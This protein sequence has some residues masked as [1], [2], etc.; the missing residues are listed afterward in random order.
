[1]DVLH[2]FSTWDDTERGGGSR[3]DGWEQCFDIVLLSCWRI[4]CIIWLIHAISR[5]SNDSIVIGHLWHDRYWPASSQPASQP[6]SH[7]PEPIFHVIP[8]TPGY[9]EPPIPWISVDI[10]LCVVSM[11]IESVGN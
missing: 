9:P 10:L 6:A 4:H 2:A 3:W 8:W 7:P 1:M 5:L 11:G